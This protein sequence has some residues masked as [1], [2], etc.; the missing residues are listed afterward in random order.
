MK[1]LWQQIPNPIITDIMSESKVFDG[2]VLD[3]EH[4]GF[5]IETVN[6]LIAI[7]IAKG[8]ECFVRVTEPN[9]TFVRQ[10]LDAGATGMI[11][12]NIN[13]KKAIEFR[14]MC[15][16]P[17]RGN[18]GLGLTRNNMWGKNGLLNDCNVKLVAQIESKFA[19]RDIVGIRSFVNFDYYMIGPYDLSMDLKCAGEFDNPKFTDCIDEFME[20]IPKK[21][22]GFHAV[23]VGGESRQQLESISKKYGFIACGLDTLALVD[24][25]KHVERQLC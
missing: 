7:T 3:T 8:K 23:H 2:I 9:E 16:Y 10:C 25:I 13:R 5:N 6:T 14:S 17:P 1:M 4:A 18:R 19:V 24:Y 22:R 12:A 11:C 21:K 15:F 20:H